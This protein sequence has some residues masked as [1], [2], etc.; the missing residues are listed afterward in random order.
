[1]LL[2]RPDYV[3]TVLIGEAAK[4]HKGSANQRAR[5]LLGN[6]LLTAAGEVHAERR[7]LIQPAFARTRLDECAAVVVRRARAMCDRWRAGEVVDVVDAIGQL[8]FGIVGETIV[9]GLVDA[10]FRQV[11]EAVSEAIA[12]L[13]PLVS[14]VAPLR[15]V[16]RAQ[17]RLR[18]VVAEL[19]SRAT[20]QATEG[21]LLAL[22]NA[23]DAQGCGS[24]AGLQPRRSAGLQPCHQ[25]SEQRIDDLL[26]ILVAG[27]D[28]I[29]SAL[30]WTLALVAAHPEVERDMRDELKAVLAGRDATAADVGDL[31]YTRAVL[32]E[33]LRLY[34][35][36]WVLARHAAESHC[37]DEG[38]VQAGTI[39]LVSQYLL[40]RDGR[41]FERPQAFDPRRWLA[42][43]ADH[44]RF[45]YFPFGAGARACIGESFGWMEGVLLLATIALRWR[46]RTIGAFPEID[47]R[48]TMRPRGPVL[49]EVH[50]H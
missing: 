22:L 35:P 2:N 23:H 34:P 5:R 33:S 37:F 49:M 32:A 39:V 12:S 45:A 26:T 31:V 24:S 10:E 3:S 6:G 29:T 8:T 13:D 50:P 42:G 16:R 19:A 17:S 20:E 47:L 7:R 21:S 18:T 30:S 43:G 15:R 27:H 41:F 38:E 1:V 36:A 14:L 4:F 28:T 9:G 48:I 40:H 25:P 46:L 11:Q 44:P